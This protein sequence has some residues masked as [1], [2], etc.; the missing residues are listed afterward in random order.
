MTARKAVQGISAKEYAERRRAVLDAVAPQSALLL[1]AGRELLRNGDTHYPFRQRSDFLYLTGFQEPDAILVFLPGRRAGET[2]L[3]CRDHDARRERYDGPRLGPEQAAEA[4]GLD[5][6]FP[7]SDIDDILPG[8][9]EDRSQVYLPLGADEAF[10]AQVREWIEDCRS[11]RGGPVA[12]LELTDSGHILHELRLFKS[13]AELRL[14]REAARISVLAHERAMAR[15]APG[16]PE[17]VL[18]AEIAYAFRSEGATGPA[19]PSIVG[20]GANACIMHYVDNAA[21]LPKDG[22][23]LIDAGA[24]YQGYAADITRTFPASGRFTPLQRQLYDLVFAAQ[25][26]AIEAVRP[27]ATFNDPHLAS[28]RVLIAGLIELKVLT[29]T[30]DGILADGSAMPFL[31]HRCSHWL[32]IDV[33]DVGEYRFGEAWRILEPGMVLTIEPGLYFPADL[34]ETPPAFAGIGLRIEDDVL[35]TASGYEVLTAAAPRDGDA[36]EA[37]MAQGGS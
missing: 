12:A 16:V 22:L 23:V 32:G 24:E 18:E 13:P 3:F 20:G 21:P 6:A 31:V 37:L 33:H 7:L 5:D 10:E 2:V 15:A 30:V 8:L 14:M 19:Y 9:L 29:G 1:P 26:A 27:G 11:R 35:V 25:T 28:Q 17:Y 34:P 4:L 36:I